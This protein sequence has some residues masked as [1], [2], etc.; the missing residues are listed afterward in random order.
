MLGFQPAPPEVRP[1]REGGDPMIK[2]ILLN[3]VLDEMERLETRLV[4]VFEER[5]AGWHET[6]ASL[7]RQ[8][9]LC[10]AEM[11]KLVQ[12]DLTMAD[13]DEQA[14]RAATETFCGRVEQHQRDWPMEQ[15]DLDNPRC[16]RPFHD[17]RHASTGFKTRMRSI[18]DVYRMTDDNEFV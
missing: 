2:H 9:T 1:P 4:D 11:F 16:A 14:L 6:Y 15:V 18:I 12:D 5:P 13:N 17:V 3:A 10:V 7:R 8:I